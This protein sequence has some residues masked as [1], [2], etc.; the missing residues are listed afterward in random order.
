MMSYYKGKTIWIIGASS[1]IGK[2]LAQQ[3]AGQGAKLILSARNKEQLEE[4]N[5]ELGGLHHVYQLDV[6]DPDMIKRTVGAVRASVSYVDSVI[7]MA[8]VYAPSDSECTDPAIIKQ[9]VDVNL[10]GA[11]YCSYALLPMFKEQGFG[12]LA[13]CASVAGY[14]GLPA[15]QPYSATKAGLI[16]FAESLRVET[17]PKIDIKVINPGF[18]KTRMTDKNTFK[19][20]MIITADKAAIHIMK[21]LRKSVFEIHF[22]K[23]FT[24]FM[25]L[26][27]NVPYRLYFFIARRI[28]T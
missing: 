13:L 11:I 26:I 22:P 12:Q 4:L 25:K 7:F 8:A 24:Y 21:G 3:L 6:T 19:M 15:G 5:K 14:V 23:K 28:E 1:G 17:D 18:V 10:T 16:N 9:I 2:A 20:P 27:G